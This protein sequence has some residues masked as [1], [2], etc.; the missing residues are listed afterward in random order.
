MPPQKNN[1]ITKGINI[2]KSTTLAVPYV[3]PQLFANA[4]ITAMHKLQK[5]SKSFFT[6]Q[7]SETEFRADKNILLI[8]TIIML[9]YLISTKEQSHCHPPKTHYGYYTY[10]YIANDAAIV[11]IVSNRN[12]PKHPVLQSSGFLPVSLLIF[13]CSSHNFT[14]ASRCSFLPS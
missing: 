4:V 10:I 3:T 11:D 6:T 12:N 13:F 5:A 14:N 2:T 9:Y 7:G 1:T 8:F